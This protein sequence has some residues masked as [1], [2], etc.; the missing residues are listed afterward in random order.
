MEE[1]EKERE[2][3]GLVCLSID[4]FFLLCWCPDAI[5]LMIS[6]F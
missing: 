6:S 3:F 1:N 4:F 5:A 2:N